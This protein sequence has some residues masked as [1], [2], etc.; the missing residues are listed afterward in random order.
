MEDK[1]DVVLFD[2][3]FSMFGMRARIALAEK[4]IEYKYEEQNLTNKSPLLLQMNP[5]HKKIPVLIHNA[6]PICESLVIVEYIDEVW[7][8]RTPL[9]PSNPHHKA[10][11]RFWANFV[12]QKVRAFRAFNII[13]LQHLH[14][15]NIFMFDTKISQLVSKYY[16]TAGVWCFEKDMDFKGRRASGGKEGIHREFKEIR[17]GSWR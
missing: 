9:L 1:D 12:D 3:G 14:P 10:Q 7:N 17:G 5:V 4:G 11:A 13:D 15:R 2:F 6:K 8:Q 16:V